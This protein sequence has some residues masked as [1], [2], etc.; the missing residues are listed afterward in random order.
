MQERENFN[1]RLGFILV[2]AG[3]AIGLGNVWKFPYICGENGGAAFILIY[4]VF[5]VI[6]GWPIMMAEFAVGRASRRSVA[7]SFFL[8]E[9]KKSRWHH[10]KWFGIAGNYLLMM[11]Y[12][13]VAGW[14]LYYAYRAT[15][16]G[17]YVL[18]GEEVKIA[19]DQM[20][21]SPGVLI[22]W[23]FIVI[24]ISFSICAI[25]LQNGVEKITK[26]MML[27]LIVLMV[28]LAINSVTIENASEGLKFYLIPDFGRLKEQGVGN[29]IFAAMTHAFFT[30][31]VGMG[32][33]SIFGSYMDKKHKITVESMNVVLLDTFVALMAGVI[34]IPSCFAYGI[35][36]DSGPSLL[37]ITLPN[38][39]HNMAGGRI[40]EPLFFIFMTF[41]AL[42]TVIAVFENIMAICMEIFDVSRKKAAIVNFCLLSI[43]SIPA[44]LGYNVLSHVQPIGAGSSIMGLEDFIVSYNIL[45]LGGLFFVLFCIKKN[46]WGFENFLAE[47]NEG[48]GFS[49]PRWIKGYMT[50]VLPLIIIC[51][52]LKGYYDM[53]TSYGT[54]TLLFWMIVAVV[55]LGII[56]SFTLPAKKSTK[57]N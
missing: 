4:L 43:L 41:A 34:I 29:V 35:Q 11:F 33:M 7:K 1:S 47:V 20:L 10:F 31:S 54:Q 44:I 21:A 9:G 26:I 3:C 24:A 37:F 50:Y 28:I 17:L 53:F 42:S 14:M 38:V 40:W 13:M 49:L 25:G 22:F 27:L 5:L 36:P 48:S 2:S 56:L 55:F 19:F 18:N 12:T 8:L 46:G 45:P 52:Y 15:T 16:G 57:K 23:T 6:L 32:S 51:V 30:L 39:F